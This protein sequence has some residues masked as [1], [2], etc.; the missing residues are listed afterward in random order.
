MSRQLVGVLGIAIAVAG[1]ATNS[2]VL[3]WVAIGV[4]LAA[5]LWRVVASSRAR[6]HRD[7]LS[8]RP[9]DRPKE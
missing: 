4:L 7:G 2:R 9:D 5:V 1:I 3:I 6:K 8:S